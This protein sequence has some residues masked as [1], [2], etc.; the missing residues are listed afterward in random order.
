M[1]VPT[2]DRAFPPMRRWSTM[3]TGDSPSMRS[4]CGRVHFG[5]RLRVNGGNVSFS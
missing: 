3:I 4:A 2:V 5:S 1:I